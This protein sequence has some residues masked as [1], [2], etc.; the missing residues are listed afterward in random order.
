MAPEHPTETQMHHPHN[1]VWEGSKNLT[2]LLDF[3]YVGE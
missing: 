3:C 2:K 1:G